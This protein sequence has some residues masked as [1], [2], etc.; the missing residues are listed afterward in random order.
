MACTENVTTTDFFSQQAD[1][2]LDLY[3]TKTTFKDRLSLFIQ[4]LRSVLPDGGRV[5]DFG[6]GPGIMT[7]AFAEL[8]YD[9]LGIDGAEQMIEIARREQRRRGAANVE[10]GVLDA[11]DMTLPSQAFDRPSKNL[12][13]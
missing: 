11:V 4:K 13:Q 2:W 7:L 5:L 1:R 10:F 3:Q 8:G 12:S 6:C 9:V